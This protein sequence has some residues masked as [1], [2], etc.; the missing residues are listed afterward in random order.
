MEKTM[1]TVIS[2]IA[3]FERLLIS[4]WVRTG[5]AKARANGK[6]HGRP[7]INAQVVQEIRRLRRQGQSWRQ[8]AR[9]LGISRQTVAN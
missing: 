2:A 6:R 1:L 5:I 3:E 9:Q 8:I 7:K 4:E